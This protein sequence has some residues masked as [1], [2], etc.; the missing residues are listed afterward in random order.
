MV[1]PMKPRRLRLGTDTDPQAAPGPAFPGAKLAYRSP[2]GATVSADQIAPRGDRSDVRDAIARF[3]KL[4]AGGEMPSTSR[5]PPAL[6]PALGQQSITTIAVT[7]PELA[8]KT[9]GAADEAS[10]HLLM[11]CIGQDSSQG[12]CWRS[13]LIS[14]DFGRSPDQHTEEVQQGSRRPSAEIMAAM[15]AT[16]V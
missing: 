10:P 3:K 16:A 6:K 8:S 2:G 13:D 7:A 4:A 11:E 12:H 1:S 5:Q 9:Q 15:G 14:P